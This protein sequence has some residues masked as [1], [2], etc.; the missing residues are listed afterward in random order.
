MDTHPTQPWYNTRP[1]PVFMIAFYCLIVLIQAGL[2]VVGTGFDQARQGDISFV[3]F[4]NIC[5]V[6]LL[7]FV[8]GVMLLTRQKSCSLCFVLALACGVIFSLSQVGSGS[9]VHLLTLPMF[10]EYA[11][12]FGIWVYSLQL[13]T[14]SYFARPAIAR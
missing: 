13:R 14:G 1:A 10:K 6:A 4:L 3:V 12:I 11:L 2:W 5:V 8:G 7:I 9:I